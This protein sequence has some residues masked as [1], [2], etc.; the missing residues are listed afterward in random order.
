MERYTWRGTDE[1][2][3]FKKLS[4]LNKLIF[5]S[6]RVDF[7]NYKYKDYKAYMITWVKHAKSR[8]RTVTYSYPDQKK[9]KSY[10]SS[11][12]EGDEDDDSDEEIVDSN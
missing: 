8:Q 12:S 5:Q 11:S 7:S 9:S 3:S 6:V 4:S 10:E 1:K 2:K